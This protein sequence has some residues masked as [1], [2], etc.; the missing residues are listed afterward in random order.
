MT[1]KGCPACQRLVQALGWAG[2]I[3]FSL[4]G[5]AVLSELLWQATGIRVGELREASCA[6]AATLLVGV[7][8]FSPSTILRSAG[9]AIALMGHAALAN[10]ISPGRGVTGQLAWLGVGA[11][12]GALVGP[13]LVRRQSCDTVPACQGTEGAGAPAAVPQPQPR[14][15]Q[16]TLPIL[17][18]WAVTGVLLLILNARDN[19]R[20]AWQDR[21][22]AAVSQSRGH[23]LFD[24]FGVPTLVF[25]WRSRRPEDEG[26]T[27][28][29]LRCIDLGSR[30][31]DEQLSQLFQL[32]LK[33]LPDLSEIRL[34]R[35]LV[36]DDGLVDVAPL[37]RLES[38]SVGRA[39][40]NVGL[41]HL[42]GL[43][44]LRTLDLS[45][46]QI[47]GKGLCFPRHLPDLQILSLRNTRVA[48]E[49]LVFLARFP[50]LISVD[51]AGTQISDAGLVYLTA[52]PRLQSLRVEHTGVSDACVEQLKRMPRLQWLFASHTRLTEAG[53]RTLWA[54]RPEVV[55]VK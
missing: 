18:A 40:T 15:F 10:S 23:V 14:R 55:V 19:Q 37:V 51:L 34:D 31:G 36:T 38:L 5:G 7:W 32:G 21:M 11:A 2:A 28:K 48:D 49:D 20:V 33:E 27:R 41:R 12:L 54:T 35:S 26:E 8:L 42:D 45:R 30:A 1:W 6:L 39:T 13:W 24:D 46:T 29:S 47:T 50:K 52:L 53:V 3:V 25:P 44:A 43:T 16:V 4:P 9:W 17:G 22:A